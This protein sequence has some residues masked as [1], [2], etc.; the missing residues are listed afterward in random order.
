MG[1]AYNDYMNL[2]EQ[3][4]KNP[5]DVRTAVFDTLLESGMS[6]AEATVK[7]VRMFDETPH[8]LEVFDLQPNDIQLRQVS[9]DLAIKADCFE[10]VKMLVAQADAIYVFLTEGKVSQDARNT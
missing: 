3:D 1:N 4:Q 6:S 8:S 10:D 7:V 9:V 2:R 5:R